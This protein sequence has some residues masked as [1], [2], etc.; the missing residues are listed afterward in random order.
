[1]ENILDQFYTKP[2][3]ALECWKHLKYTIESLDMDFSRLYFIEPSAG[4][5]AFFN[6]MPKSRRMGVDIDPRCN[7]VNK[8]D[9]LLMTDFWDTELNVVVGNPPFGKRG[10]LAVSFFNHAS[11]MADIVAFI[12]PFN[13]KKFSMQTQLDSRMHF[14]SRMELPENAFHL[15]DNKDY[16][17][18]CEFQIWTNI[19]SYH[20][21]LREFRPPQSSHED[22]EIYQ[23]NNTDKAI[24]IFE[25][26][27][28][29]AVP[30]QGWQDY[31]R[32][33]L[34][35]EKCE[36]NKQWMLISAKNA[37]VLTRL[38]EIDYES[39]SKKYSTIIPGFRKNDLIREYKDL[40]E[41]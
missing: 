22:F 8:G 31:K 3:V 27:F 2:E 26:K 29:F 30:C 15:P 38:L 18:N 23:Y 39:L 37:K 24:N 12:L 25:N 4:C 41:G 28:D 36:K 6:L 32:K 1:M 13:F 16:N 7:G 19:D 10:R 14:I 9:F 20:K 35:K 17:I 33:E 5:G 11:C 40:Y 21:D 34:D